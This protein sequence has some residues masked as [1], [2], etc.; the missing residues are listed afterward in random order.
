M[1]MLQRRMASSIYAVR[2]SLER[3]KAKREEILADPEAYRRQRIERRIPDDFDELPDDEQAELL[4][5]LEDEVISVD[6]AVLREDIAR[7]SALIAQAR[8]LEARGVG[9]K[10]AELRRVLTEIGAFADP[11]RSC[12]SS[13][14]TRTRS[15]TSRATA[16]TAGRSASSAS[17]GCR[18]PRF[19][20]G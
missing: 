18:S 11:R 2:R 7:L 15:I 3:M 1:A 13:P 5:Q 8:G 6:P 4:S 10:L 12:C 16:R 14:S 20:A 19:T 9:T 17:G